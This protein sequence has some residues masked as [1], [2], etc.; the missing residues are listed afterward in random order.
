MHLVIL[1]GSG[2]TS[3]PDTE[4]ASTLLVAATITAL[5]PISPHRYF[6]PTKQDFTGITT[7]VF[8]KEMPSN[9]LVLA[10]R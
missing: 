6:L 2:E 4:I 9:T 7:N 3:R 10:H 1:D 8:E 5:L